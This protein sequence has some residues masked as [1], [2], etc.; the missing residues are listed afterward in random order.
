[1]PEKHRSCFVVI[2]LLLIVGVGMSALARGQERA[3]APQVAF[4]NADQKPNL[5]AN[6]DCFDYV[7]NVLNLKDNDHSVF[8]RQSDCIRVHVTNNPFLFKYELSFNEQAVKEDD[9]L[10][11]LAKPLGLN[12]SNVSSTTGSSPDNKTSDTQKVT[13]TQALSVE[14]KYE[15]AITR[16]AQ[17]SKP[18]D[19]QFEVLNRQVMEAVA[20][21]RTAF[22]VGDTAK[23]QEKLQTA[24]DMLQSAAEAAGK[25]PKAAESHNFMEKTGLKPLPSQDAG[26]VRSLQNNIE[27]LQNSIETPAPTASQTSDWAKRLEALQSAVEGVDQALEAKTKLYLD[28]SQKLPD[29]INELRDLTVDLEKQPDEIMVRARAIQKDANRLLRQLNDSNPAP[30]SFESRID[31]QRMVDFAGPAKKLHDELTKSLP[32]GDNNV[33]N[34]LE[35]LHKAGQKVVVDA[36]TYNTVVENDFPTIRTGLLDHLEAVLNDGTNYTFPYIARKREGPFADPM[37]VTMTLKRDPATPFA[38]SSDNKAKNTTASFKCSNDTTDLF[39]NGDKYA[40]FDDFFSDKPAKNTDEANTY[41][42]NQNKPQPTGGTGNS[43]A[44]NQGGNTTGPKSYPPDAPSTVVLEQPWTFGRP[45]WVVSG[46]L[47]SGIISKQE[48]QRTMTVS[49]GTSET[50]VGLKS[51][52]KFRTNPMLFAHTLLAYS[53]HDA[54]AW[55]ATLGVTSSSDNQS[56]NPEFLVGISRSLAQQRFFITG[57]A[58]I[59]EQQKLAGGLALGQ[60]L[61]STFTGDIPVTKSYHASFGFGFSYRITGSKPSQD[62]SKPAASTSTKPKK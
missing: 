8:W 37:L 39:D 6:K 34:L 59:G 45:R 5:D 18:T 38:T 40:T 26:A 23:Q 27:E 3:A 54:D 31:E 1:M 36:C 58:Y 10:G 21:S 60:V 15:A 20:D 32:S 13:A 43:T 41:T 12:V 42:S 11:S 51:D 55:Y 35:K 19:E 49:N 61:P 62:N 7:L 47:S 56:T 2:R 46:G 53:R 48:F 25:Q 52:S 30:G 9:P 29:E 28:F 33:S 57:G 22:I 50:V 24:H 14:S 16:D 4:V 44:S 17:I